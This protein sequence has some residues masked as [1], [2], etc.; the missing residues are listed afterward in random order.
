M[1]PRL[2]QARNR[3]FPIPWVLELDGSLRVGPIDQRVT[4]YGATSA[5]G[6][7]GLAERTD[8]TAFVCADVGGVRRRKKQFV[9]CASPYTSPTGAHP[10]ANPSS[11]PP[12]VH[13][14]CSRGRRDIVREYLP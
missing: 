6:P 3:V 1:E 5:C 4:S 9:Y 7:V 8:T 13:G 11:R 12:K 2:I 14:T 10:S